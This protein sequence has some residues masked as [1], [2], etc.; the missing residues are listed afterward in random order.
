MTINRRVFVAGAPLLL[1]GC[2]TDGRQAS[3]MP[4]FRFDPGYVSMYAAASNEPF[5]VPAID[6]SEV[7]PDFLRREVAFPTREPPG[8]IVVYPSARYA[9]LVLPAG[10]AIRYGVGVGKEEGFNFRGTAVIGRKAEWPSWTPTPNMIRREP[11]RYGKYAGGLQGG[12]DNPLGPRALYLYQDG[13]DTFYRLHGT[14]EPSTIGTMVSSGCVRLMNQDIIDL[15]NRVPVGSRV[16]VM[17]ASAAP[18]A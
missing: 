2:V 1:A 17:P 10:R 6:L 7:N 16:V 13:R 9:F 5:P 18:V 8:T 4:S 3:M 11:A 14:T 12:P 15:Y